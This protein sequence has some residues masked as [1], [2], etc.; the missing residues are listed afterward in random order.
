MWNP[1]HRS[2]STGS[3][4]YPSS[5]SPNNSDNNT[6][7]QCIGANQQTN[8]TS[9]STSSSNNSTS[10]NLHSALSIASL[11]PTPQSYDENDEINEVNS[12]NNK[13]T[14]GN[15]EENDDSQKKQ[16]QSFN[17]L[18]NQQALGARTSIGSSSSSSNSENINTSMAN[19]SD[20]SATSSPNYRSPSISYNSIGNLHHTSNYY[21]H[22]AS[23]ASMNYQHA[24]YF[25]PQYAAVAAAQYGVHP[26]HTNAAYQYSSALNELHNSSFNS[27]LSHGL[28]GLVK[29]EPAYTSSTP[30]F[31][32]Y[33]SNRYNSS[34]SSSSS[35]S[36]SSTAS[37][38]DLMKL[39][40][41]LAVTPPNN[42]VSTQSAQQFSSQAQHQQTQQYN[43]TAGIYYNN[44][45]LTNQQAPTNG[46]SFPYQN[47]SNSNG[48]NPYLPGQSNNSLSPLNQDS[49]LSSSSSSSSASTINERNKAD[50][51]VPYINEPNT[52]IIANNYPNL[53]TNPN[54]K[55]KLQ[56]TSLWRQFGHIGTEMIIT[57][58]GRRMFPA[59]RVSV[60][61]LEASAK[62]M[63]IIDVIPVDDNR[64]KFHNCEWI[65][66]GKAEAHFAGR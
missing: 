55:V 50:A 10:N 52:N 49:Q 65:V 40:P 27:Y 8:S 13:N 53:K 15:V 43:Q 34:S 5:D 36:N 21:N 56:D 30:A 12:E 16:Q 35:S 57:K 23:A 3:A 38:N 19:S 22:P 39:S 29:N 46:G 59:I 61:G 9:S 58:G 26:A 47:A 45:N 20:I 60:S 25:N 62:Y 14:T 42:P 44:L 4:A 1:F 33:T 32:P 66:S 28:T 54:I 37:V 41:P 6:A 31:D 48:Y 17:M 18:P 2:N 64:Y 51:S 63:M 7:A 11:I 24:N